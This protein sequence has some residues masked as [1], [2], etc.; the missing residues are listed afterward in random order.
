MFPGWWF[1][2]TEDEQGW[3]PSSYLEKEDGGQDIRI[4]ALSKPSEGYYKSNMIQ[5]CTHTHHQNN[6]IVCY[7]NIS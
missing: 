6:L 3:A 5:T 2:H 1:I 7:F 4:V